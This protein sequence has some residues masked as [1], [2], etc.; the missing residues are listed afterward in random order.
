M[1]LNLLK[2]WLCHMELWF[3]M[4]LAILAC[5]VCIVISIARDCGLMVVCGLAMWLGTVVFSIF[6]P[7]MKHSRGYDRT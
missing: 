1:W 3:C 5:G 4:C 2:L 7:S 6:S